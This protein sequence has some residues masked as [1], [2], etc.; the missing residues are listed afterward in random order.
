MN[1]RR[2][3]LRRPM[4]PL[5]TLLGDPRYARPLCTDHTSARLCTLPPSES[6]FVGL[7]TGVVGQHFGDD[8]LGRDGVLWI[9]PQRV[10][11]HNHGLPQGP[12]APS[13]STQTGLPS[14]SAARASSHTC[15]ARTV[16]ISPSSALSASLVWPP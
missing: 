1:S 9:V 7:C 3:S 11:Q 15:A 6:R 12:P 10:Y 2:A 14:H 8:F 4:K 5:L 16:S 13:P